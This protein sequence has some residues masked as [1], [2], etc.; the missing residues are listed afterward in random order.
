[1]T[2]QECGERRERWSCPLEE[3][4]YER[5]DARRVAVVGGGMVGLATAWFL[6]ERGA[7]VT[8]FERRHIGAGS[9]WGN[10]GWLTPALTTPLPE[11]A[12][13]G[14]GLRAVMDPTSPVYLPLRADVR[15]WRFLLG[16]ARRC[17]TR[18]W[19]RAMAAYVTVN[20][21]ALDAYDELGAGGVTAPTREADPF[22]VC[23]RGSTQR[24]GMLEELDAVLSAGQKIDFE[25][26]DGAE[27]R[28]LD[29]VLT[30]HVGAAVR[31][32]GQRYIDPP[33]YVGALAGA[34]RARGATILE[35]RAVRD[36]SDLGDQVVVRADH[37]DHRFDAAV[38]ATGAWLDQ[39][40]RRFGVR[41]VQAGRGYSFSV[42][43][44]EMPTG[45][46]YLPEQR[47]ACTP[48]GD[49]LRVAGM[50]EFRHPDEP[51]DPRRSQA[52]VDAVRPFLHGLELR[53]RHDEW[54]GSRPCTVDG[55]PL[56]GRT[57]SPRVFAAGGHGMWGIALGPL[58]GQLLAEAIVTGRTPPALSPFDPLR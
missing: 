31:L 26:L 5:R 11:P 43:V 41:P 40:A 17:T 38:L 24:R 48:L 14:Y 16:F 3:I 42:P 27:A 39:L 54:V 22:L 28:R 4:H 55:L 45:P 46:V 10:A 58:S 32:H 44:R 56:V 25:L 35:D 12:V 19:R 49:R 29:P 9:S 7:E 2:S 51:L 47:V 6:Q 20:D 13:L 34:V 53:K 52:V 18:Q 8:V 33:A 15:L 21:R 1:M 23:F 37:G 57:T 30:E 36:V 50:M